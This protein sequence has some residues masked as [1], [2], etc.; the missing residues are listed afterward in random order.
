MNLRNSSGVFTK[1]LIC[2]KTTR[3]T[4]TLF[5]KNKYIFK[6]KRRQHFEDMN[7]D[8]EASLADKVSVRLSLIMQ[9][10]E[11]SHES[12]Q[13]ERAAKIRALSERQVIKTGI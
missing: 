11:K 4:R 13:N 5:V 10:E 6:A 2:S 9:R 12:H 1:T 8:E 3:F 7:R